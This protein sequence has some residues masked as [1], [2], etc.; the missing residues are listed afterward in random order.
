[1]PLIDISKRFG[2]CPYPDASQALAVL[3]SREEVGSQ[4]VILTSIQP[5][6][7]VLKV[8][9]LKEPVVVKTE[10]EKVSTLDKIKAIE[11]ALYP[12]VKS[13]EEYPSVLEL[14]SSEEE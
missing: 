6:D 4:G 12:P 5:E 13:V 1:M 2:P 8:E 3:C 9:E 10:E 14:N 7:Y 11:E